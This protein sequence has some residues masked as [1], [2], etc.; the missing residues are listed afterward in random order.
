MLE[1]ERKETAL[2]LFNDLEG[3]MS[4]LYGRWLDEREFESIDDYSVNIKKH[5]VGIGGEFVKM[6]K[7][8]FGFVYTLGG[9]TY[10]ITINSSRYDYKR[11]A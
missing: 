2:K 10:Q 8:P 9:A 1:Q 4:A 11:I 6:V 5:I 3:L 7:R